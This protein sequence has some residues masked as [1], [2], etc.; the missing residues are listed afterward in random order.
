MSKSRFGEESRP[1]RHEAVVDSPPKPSRLDAGELYRAH[2]PFIASF[3]VRLGVPARDVPDLVQDV[4]LIAHRKG[5]FTDRGRAKPRTWLGSIAFRVAAGH[6]RR[7]RPV[8]GLPEAPIPAGSDPEQEVQA[9][10]AAQRVEACLSAL[11]L[12]HRAVFVLFEIEGLSGAEVAEV[13]EIPAGTVYRRLSN[14]R[15]RFAE[16]HARMVAE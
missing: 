10:R 15:H 14:A 6:R 9:R 12:P 2:A 5:G 4:F 8:V 1:P 11:D 13:L 3:L 7:R 16:A